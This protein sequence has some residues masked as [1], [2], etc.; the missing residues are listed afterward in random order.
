MLDNFKKEVFALATQLNQVLSQHEGAPKISHA[1]LLNIVAKSRGFSCIQALQAKLENTRFQRCP[2]CGALG[3][4]SA[5]ETVF[6]EAGVFDGK[7]FEFEGDAMMYQCDQCHQGFTDYFQSS[8]AL[9]AKDFELWS[10]ET[11]RDYDFRSASFVCDVS[12]LT[13]A[14]EL[15]REDEVVSNLSKAHYAIVLRD[16]RDARTAEVL[17]VKNS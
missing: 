9:H 10:Y 14:Q 3:S 13:H 17:L 1:E 15:L 11:A 12:S 5:T 16:A 2:H 7:Q 8:E 4:V 6:I